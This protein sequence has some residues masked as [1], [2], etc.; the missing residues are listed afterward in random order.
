MEGMR[1]RHLDQTELT[2]YANEGRGSYCWLTKRLTK[3]LAKRLLRCR[4]FA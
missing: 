2:I 3:R 1:S 4:G